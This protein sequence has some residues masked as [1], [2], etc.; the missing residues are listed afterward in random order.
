MGDGYAWMGD[1][2][3]KS[4]LAQN[5]VQLSELEPGRPTG[6]QTGRDVSHQTSARFCFSLAPSSLP[7]SP[8]T[9]VPILPAVSFPITAAT[10]QT[11]YHQTLTRLSPDLLV[12]RLVPSC[13]TIACQQK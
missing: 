1:A 10:D 2:Q 13:L 3:N 6:A 8:P 9:S 7:I 4:K 12:F 11:L 5:Q